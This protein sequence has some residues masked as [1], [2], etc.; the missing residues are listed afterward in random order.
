MSQK[1][2]A[3]IHSFIT[4]A[5]IDRFSKFFYCCIFQEICNKTYVKLPITPYMCHCTTLRKTGNRNLQ[6]SAAFNTITL[7]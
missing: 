5:N 4:F 7:A 1:N 2:C 3:T 6:N